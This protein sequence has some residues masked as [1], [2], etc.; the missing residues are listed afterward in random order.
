MV[1]VNSIN[2]QYTR[3]A[4]GEATEALYYVHV[5]ID[6]APETC[7]RITPAIY[8]AIEEQASDGDYRDGPDYI[9]FKPAIAWQFSRVNGAEK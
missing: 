9:E 1:T 5:Q 6:G 7:Q 8:E 4:W 2:I 3:K